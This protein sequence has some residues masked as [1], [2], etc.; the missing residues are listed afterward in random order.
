M[1]HFPPKVVDVQWAWPLPFWT[2]NWTPVTPVEGNVHTIFGYS[3]PLRSRIGNLY[4]IGRQTDKQTNGRATPVMRPIPAWQHA[5]KLNSNE[6]L[7]SVRKRHEWRVNFNCRLLTQGPHVMYVSATSCNA[8][9]DRGSE[10][11]ISPTW[12]D[13]ALIIYKTQT[14]KTCHVKHDSFVRSNFYC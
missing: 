10:S 14:H 4:M 6:Q 12:G 11:Q 13:R 3:M 7:N 9:I 2:E 1:R 5:N 8:K